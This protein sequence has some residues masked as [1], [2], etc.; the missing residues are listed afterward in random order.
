MFRTFFAI[1]L[2]GSCVSLAFYINQCN[3][4]ADSIEGTFNIKLDKIDSLNTMVKIQNEVMKNMKLS[5]DKINAK[6]DSNTI[7]ISSFP[8]IKN[9]DNRKHNRFFQ[10]T[11]L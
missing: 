5:M 2:I 7:I 1:G 9:N 6:V 11:N 4:K 10:T 3:E 8:K